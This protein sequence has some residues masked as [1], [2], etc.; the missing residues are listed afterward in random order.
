L[1]DGGWLN[2]PSGLVRKDLT[3]KPAYDALMDLIKNQWWLSPTKLVSDGEGKIRLNGYL[4]DYSVSWK[5][6]QTFFSVDTK[7]K[8]TVEIMI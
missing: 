7:D 1:R 3:N 2:A 6:K 5:D 4:G 8:S